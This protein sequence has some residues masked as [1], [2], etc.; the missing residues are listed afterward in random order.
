M[1][2]Y[3]DTDPSYWLDLVDGTDHNRATMIAIYEGD[4]SVTG[5]F[6]P[7]CGTHTGYSNNNFTQQ[8]VEDY[9][10]AAFSGDPMNFMQAVTEWL[11]N[12]PVDRSTHLPFM[13]S[14]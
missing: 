2:A 7:A 4:T 12:G 3:E 11:T 1:L 6:S 9:D 8:I 13:H 14:Q 10:G 5:I